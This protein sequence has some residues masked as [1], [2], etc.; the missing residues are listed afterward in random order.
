MSTQRNNGTNPTPKEFASYEQ[1]T[2]A[3]KA[4]N[5]PAVHAA[6]DFGISNT[7]AVAYVEGAVHHWTRPTEGD[8]EPE[9]ARAILATGGV[10]LPALQQLAVTGGRHRLLPRQI[11][12][13]AVVAVDEVQAIGRGGQAM[14]NVL[15]AED[16]T[17]VLVVSAG[18]GTAVVAA[19]GDQ[20]THVTGTGVGGGTLL[21]L[22]RL[23]LGTVDHR[24][25]DALALRGDPNGADLSLS[26]AIGVPLGRLPADATAVNFGRLARRALTASREDLAAALVTLVSQV[27]ALIAINAARAERIEH[28]IVIGHLTDMTS[29]R[30]ALALVGNYYDVSIGLPADA[31]YATALGALLYSASRP[32]GR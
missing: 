3:L 17:P 8:P 10:E 28:I 27:I 19:R 12:T 6:I 32:I 23:L 21:G 7:D 5:V 15:G 18:S 11:G 13:C 9:L 22:S 26:D 1:V 30:D 4:H 25:I 16:A 31:G 2:G 24:E 29:V 14:T 20:Y